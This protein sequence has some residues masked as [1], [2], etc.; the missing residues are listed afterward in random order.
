MRNILP[1]LAAVTLLG[2]GSA[3]SGGYRLVSAGGAEL[4]APVE[5]EFFGSTSTITFISGSLTLRDDS[6]FGIT[7][8]VYSEDEDPEESPSQGARSGSTGAGWDHL[9]TFLGDDL[10]GWFV[11]FRSRIRA[12]Q[13]RLLKDVESLN[14]ST[15]P[16]FSRVAYC[17]GG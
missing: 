14:F 16:D 2:C 13:A 5:F 6:I 1:L 11:E 4:P 17:G 3:L 8:R 9:L 10:L 12:S 7:V 15:S